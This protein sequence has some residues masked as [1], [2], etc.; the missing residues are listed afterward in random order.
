VFMMMTVLLALVTDRGPQAS[1]EPLD[2]RLT[3]P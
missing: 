3:Q 2:P 1:S